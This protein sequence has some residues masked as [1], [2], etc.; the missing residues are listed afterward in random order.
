MMEIIGCSISLVVTLFAIYTLMPVAH[1][2]GLLDKPGGR[3]KHAHNTPLIGGIAIFFGF[4]FA[5]ATLPQ[6]IDAL[7]PL[8]ACSALLMLKGVADDFID[9]R[10]RYRFAM[11]LVIVVVLIFWSG[12]EVKTFGYSD[13]VG[14]LDLGAFAKP[15]SIIILVGY[16]NAVNML[17]GQDGLAGSVIFIQLLILAVLSTQ[18]A[19]IGLAQAVLLLLSALF[20]FLLLNFP[21][22]GRK[23]AYVFLGDAGSMMLAMAVGYFA[24][25]LSQSH[26]YMMHY[27]P[28]LM[29]WILAYPVFDLVSVVISRVLKRKG[30]MSPGRDHLHHLLA[31][32]GISKLASTSILSAVSLLLSLLGFVFWWLHMG[33]VSYLL[34]FFVVGL[35]YL[36][37]F[38]ALERKVKALANA[39]DKGTDNKIAM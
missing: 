17:D 31:D 10:A 39:T 12:V 27:T 6:H 13:K 3:K 1:K 33:L 34:S 24:I 35:V 29:A 22:P 18:V 4:C 5:I 30:P 8:L 9:I 37:C 20:A 36:F 15:F 19:F 23:H 38:F 14:L 26:S 25:L 16:L 28:A 2:I 32:L 7:K 11:Q 21:F